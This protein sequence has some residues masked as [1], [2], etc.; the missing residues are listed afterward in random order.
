MLEFVRPPFECSNTPACTEKLVL[1]KR[2]RGLAD[3][4]FA[5]L[6]VAVAIMK[7]PSLKQLHPKKG[8]K[9]MNERTAGGSVRN[10]EH[11]QNA[12]SDADST[13]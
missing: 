6:F 3:P 5:P 2:G 10:E 11:L 1:A 8:N 9:T 13:R 4:V 12:R 7:A